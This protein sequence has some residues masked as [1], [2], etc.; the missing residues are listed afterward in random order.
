MWLEKERPAFGCARDQ[1]KNVIGTALLEL[2]IED[3][4]SIRVGP[5]AMQSH[6][7]TVSS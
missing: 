5:V 4:G 7:P 1:R 2:L 6:D 3:D